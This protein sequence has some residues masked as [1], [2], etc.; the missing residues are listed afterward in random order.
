MQAGCLAV[1]AENDLPRL[2]EKAE[3]IEAALGVERAALSVERERA[4]EALHELEIDNTI[5]A[6]KEQELERAHKAKLTAVD[7]I[8][9]AHV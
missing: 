6:D 3:A 1:R 4:K 5:A 7:E 8:G 2:G 9:R